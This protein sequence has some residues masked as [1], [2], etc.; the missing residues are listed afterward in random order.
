MNPNA[1]AI[2]IG[3]D[4]YADPKLPSL[5][6]AEKDCRDLKTALSA[7]ESGT[8][9]EE[10]ITLLTGAEANCQNVRERLTALAVT[11][12]SPED[13][14]LIYFAGH[15]FYIPALDQAYLATPDADILQLQKD[16]SRGLRMDWLRDEIGHRSPA[17][18]IILILD[19]CYSSAVM[20]GSVLETNR[21]FMI[22]ERYYRAPN[23]RTAIVACPVEAKLR[24]DRR[25]ENGIFTHYLL[26]GL[27]GGAAEPGGAEV[28]IDSLMAYLRLHLPGFL[29]PPG[30]F[31][32]EFERIVL[33]RPRSA[34]PTPPLS[35]EAVGDAGVAASFRPLDNPVAP[36]EPFIDHLIHHISSADA[37]ADYEKV[38]LEGIC[39][40]SQAQFALLLRRG[41]GQRWAARAINS[42]A[43][44]QASLS[45]YSEKIL[46]LVA[47]VLQQHELF[48]TAHTGLCSTPAPEGAHPLH[49]AIIPLR[50]E[51]PGEILVVAGLPEHP[52][53][54][55][56]VYA[57]ILK[58][59]YVSSYDL[60]TLNA[61]IIEA[62]IYDRL[63]RQFGF[64]PLSMYERRFELF[65][66]RLQQMAIYF[67][68]I[69]F[70]DEEKPHIT[71]WEALARDPE[72]LRSPKDL[73]YAAELWGRRF[74]IEL[75]QHFIEL[76]VERYREATSQTP[77]MRRIADQLPISVN[78]YP[79]SL[80]RVAYYE[81]LREIL[82]EKRRILG[83][84]LYLEISEKRPIP[85]V[86]KGSGLFQFVEDKSFEGVLKKYIRDFQIEFA[87]DDFGV[88]HASISRLLKVYPNNV[89]IDREILKSD[90]VYY[91]IRFILDFVK[92][93]SIEQSFRNPT[94]VLEGFDFAISRK[95]DLR[96]LYDIG[97][98]YIQ[99]YLSGEPGPDLVR[100]ERDYDELIRALL[101][102]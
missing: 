53:L 47:T 90:A 85:P 84:R 25:L 37:E 44:G 74:L 102:K 87:I 27:R 2:L 32:N 1:H 19:A 60:S 49:T 75:D 96:K 3:I 43:L 78:V 46:P 11:K 54:L 98:R 30:R 82:S 29:P 88:E 66:R 36:F 63:R 64:L 12:R 26:K 56:D 97:L 94:I 4:H 89:K 48:S 39:R 92:T 41:E 57:E 52:A 7:P 10:N 100:L 34:A 59:V 21:Y 99:G 68:P 101:K 76:A 13:T 42:S 45:A 69:V 20:P 9:P 95:V 5:H 18:N 16:P 38:L 6:Y 17:R 31:G 70:L 81:K 40:A 50:R 91:A 80:I 62:G 15:G 61:E 67:Q 77:G 83:Q 55:N 24:E 86:E 33:T 22:D 65:T 28:S 93:V 35:L 79:E 51:D 8:F 23:G 71:R 73:F 58:A 72:N 14:V